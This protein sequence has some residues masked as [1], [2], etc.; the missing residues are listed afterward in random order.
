[1]LEGGWI[2]VFETP[3]W[4]K[5]VLAQMAN[6]NTAITRDADEGLIHFSF[7]FAVVGGKVFPSFGH[8]DN[9]PREKKD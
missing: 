4:A 3:G 9:T 8:G 7:S 6:K 5:A 1:M 2:G